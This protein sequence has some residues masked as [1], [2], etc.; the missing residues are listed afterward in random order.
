[1]GAGDGWEDNGLSSKR[2]ATKR[3]VERGRAGLRAWGYEKK[4]KEG[5]EGELARKC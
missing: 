2:K 4:L 5:R 1:M 3:E